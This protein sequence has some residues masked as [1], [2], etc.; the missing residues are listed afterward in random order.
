MLGHEPV[1]GPAGECLRDLADQI[2]EH[3]IAGTGEHQGM[4]ADVEVQEGGHVAR[5][6]GFTHG[7]GDLQQ[8][9]AEGLRRVFRG[10]FR[11]YGLDGGAEFGERAQLCATAF[12]GQ[13]PADDERIEGVPAVRGEDPDAN[14]LDGF[15]QSQGLQHPDGLA[16]YR[17][18]HLELV[19]KV[20]GQHDVAGGE[21]AADDPG[22]QVL[23]G[24]VVEAG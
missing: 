20:L 16:H 22:S 13:P 24:A 21:L 3:F 12:S 17:P 8:F 10:E 18:R 9:A 14:A 2:R 7:Q 5:A 11:G 6:A 1:D 15:H 23:D 4:K 19:L